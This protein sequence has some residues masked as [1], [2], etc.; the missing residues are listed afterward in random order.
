MAMNT[1]CEHP[2][3]D[4]EVRT[5]AHS[6]ARH[7]QPE[8]H[9]SGWPAPINLVELAAHDPEPPRFI[10]R[11][12]LPAGYATLLAGHGGIGKSA[13]GLHVAACIGLEMPFFG[14]ETERHRVLYLS[15]EDRTAV[16]HWRLHHLCA[17]R[18]IRLADLDG[19][20]DTLDL[21]GHDTVLWDRDPR[22]G[23][24]ITPAFGQLEQRIEQSGTQVL[25]VDGVSD[26]FG[27]NENARGR[28]QA[29]R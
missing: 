26:T 22:T 20:L 18:D 13:V 25:V 27:G 23:Y 4:D 28:G 24:T 3:G 6:A 8:A 29:L 7:A 5:I 17:Y 16:L 11:D 9:E 10:L 21:V 14:I 19:A 1:R 2:L 12:W 15:C